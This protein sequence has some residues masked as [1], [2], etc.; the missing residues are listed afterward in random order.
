M[1]RPPNHID[2]L[3]PFD[4]NKSIVAGKEVVYIILFNSKTSLIFR[5][6]LIAKNTNL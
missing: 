3:F 2:L 1:N 4:C 5:N 6:V